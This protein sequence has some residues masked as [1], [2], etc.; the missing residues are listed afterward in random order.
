MIRLL[1]CLC[2]SSG[3]SLGAAS[4]TARTGVWSS[5]PDELATVLASKAGAYR[6]R[7]TSFVCKE[8]VREAEYAGKEADSER[9]REFEYSL[10]RD[11]AAPHGLRAVRTRLEDGPQGREQTLDLEFPEPYV[12]TA[13][14]ESG[15]RSTFRFQVGEWHTTPF[16]LAIPVHWLSSAPVIGGQRVTEWS[17]TAEI[18][19]RTGNL[20]RVVARPSL[21]DERLWAQL[22][23]YL[24][25]FRFLGLSAARPPIGLELTVDFGIE[26]DRFTFPQRVELMIFQQTHRDER[27]VVSRRVIEYSDYRFFETE[28]S[29][30]LVPP[31][32][33]TPPPPSGQE[34]GPDS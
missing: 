30:E 25:A 3:V 4:P 23:R 27:Q 12:W 21:Q 5:L 33:Y 28:T 19:W 20:V 29:E 6:A 18:E 15:V 8:R 13:L 1:A 32:T 11:A 9:I 2:L 16:K 31:L 10:V 34:Q 7:A 26:R 17:G 24:T 22:Q 14:F